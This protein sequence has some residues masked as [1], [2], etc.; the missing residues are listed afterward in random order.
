MNND[1]KRNGKVNIYSRFYVL[2]S[3]K[4]RFFSNDNFKRLKKPTN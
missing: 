2:W 1:G 4:E 3:D